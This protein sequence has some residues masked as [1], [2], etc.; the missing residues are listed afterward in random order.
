MIGAHLINAGFM[1]GVGHR[2]KSLSQSYLGALA[3][4]KVALN[5]PN[6]VQWF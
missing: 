2:R 3:L 1:F 4:Q 6:H 5:A